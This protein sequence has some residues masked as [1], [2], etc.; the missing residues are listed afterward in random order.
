[1]DDRQVRFLLIE[2]NPVDARQIRAMLG[3]A[4]DPSFDVECVDNLSTGLERLGAGGIDVILL[5]LSLPDS[6]GLETLAAARTAAPGLPIIILTV[7]DDEQ[8]A[9]KAVREGAQ[10]Y[11]VKG[12]VD[13][14]GLVRSARYAIERKRAEEA[15]RKSEQK[16]RQLVENIP[17]VVY[18]AEVV[19]EPRV[20][21]VSP[22]VEELTGYP[23]QKFL[24]DPRFWAELIHPKDRQKVFAKWTGAV[25]NSSVF[26]SEYRLRRKDGRERW[27]MDIA[28][29]SQAESGDVP[30]FDGMVI[31]ISDR[32][33]AEA[34]QRRLTTAIEHAAD[35]I[36]MIDT[37]GTI[38]YVNPAFEQITGYSRE[39]AVG[40]SMQILESAEQDASFY[41]EMWDTLTTGKVWSSRFTSKKKD[42]TLYEEER[43]ISPI[44]DSSGETVGYVAVKR[45]VS[46]EV[47]LEAQLRQSQKMEAVGMLAGGVAHDF[48]NVLTVILGN[49]EFLLDSLVDS[50]PRRE[51]VAQIQAAAESAESLTRQLLAF[52][53]QQVLAPQVLDLNKILTNVEKMLRRMIG[54]DVELVTLL[55][56]ALG[57]VEADPGQVEQVILN[58][59]VNARD[60]M[61]EGGKLTIVT[62]NADLDEPDLSDDAAMIPGHYVMLAMTDTGCGMDAETRSRIFEPFFS[63][64]EIGK[65]TGLGLST[66]YGIVKQSGGHIRVDS[67]PGHGATFKIYLPRVQDAVQPLEAD[68]AT[69][70]AQLQGS[71]TVLLVEDDEAIRSV[72][73]TVL[74]RNGYRVLEAS[75]GKEAVE[76]CTRHTGPIHLMI[77]DVVMPGLNG[78]DLAERLR[79]RLPG[80]PVL[81][82]SGYTDHAVLSKEMLDPGTNFLHKPFTPIALARKVRQLLDAVPPLS[83]EIPR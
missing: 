45:D 81:Y 14:N 54:E 74:Q 10:D 3:Q 12:Q 22:R 77:T 83:N 7:S 73:K 61:P 17:M 38:Q 62:A 55:D 70:T 60:A 4:R 78:R 30:R 36:V 79:P 25:K 50:D 53:R 49:S 40:Q 6:N 58:L 82:T 2:D 65:G 32:R 27:V 47:A 80:M 13:S 37:Q 21:F 11:L 57:A 64:K 24:S 5:D 59:A 69:T 18:R 9:A 39:E 76:V 41:Q 52:S 66:V 71:E 44:R 15:L 34:T 31:D 68:D 1:M 16:Y 51:T 48:N 42:G 43:T 23:A 8:L 72:C 26:R 63:T 46:K 19:P 29:P 20:L 28:R 33:R 67:E 35:G 56:P 75:N